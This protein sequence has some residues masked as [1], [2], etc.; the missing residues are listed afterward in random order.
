[1]NFISDGERKVLQNIYYKMERLGL[2]DLRMT[3]VDI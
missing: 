2:I 3:G 1:M